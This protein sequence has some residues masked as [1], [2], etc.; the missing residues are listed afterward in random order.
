MRRPAQRQTPEVNL[1]PMLDVLMTVLTFFIIIAMTLTDQQ[2]P[3]L[4]LPGSANAEAPAPERPDPLVIGLDRQGQLL[5]NSQGIPEAEL[6]QQVRRYLA[7][8]PDGSIVLKADQTLPY[9]E[10]LTLLRRL[11]D[12]GGDRVGLATQPQS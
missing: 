10:V 6:E 1:V 8:T 7:H 4:D 3:N 2:L 12:L 5:I 9:E 11:R